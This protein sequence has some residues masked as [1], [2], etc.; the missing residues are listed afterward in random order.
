MRKSLLLLVIFTITITLY[1][2]KDTLSIAHYSSAASKLNESSSTSV[3][4]YPVPV[5]D[6]TFTIRSEKEITFIKISNIIGQDIFSSRYNNPVTTLKINLDNPK[7]GMYI[8]A[9]L[10]RDETRVV[11]K[12]MIEQTE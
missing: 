11:K 9:I 6:N 3:V 7:R 5:R 10:F 8:V 2:Q 1:S 12:I 4:I